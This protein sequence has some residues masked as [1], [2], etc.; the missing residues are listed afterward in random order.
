MGKRLSSNGFSAVEVL[1]ATSVIVVIGFISRLVWQ[2]AHT[3]SRTGGATVSVRPP[4]P[5]A[6]SYAG[7]LTAESARA[8]FSL[9]YP[10]SWKF[11]E[12][13]S[14]KDNVEHITLD[15]AN[16]HITIDSYSAESLASAGQPAVGCPDCAAVIGTDSV[17]LHGLGSAS[18]DAVTYHLDSGYS[19]ALVLMRPGSVYYVPSPAKAGVLTTFR[20]IS[21]LASLQAYQAEPPGQFAA[22][23]D[24]EV[25]K[26]IFS[27]ISY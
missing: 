22:S 6:N 18:I 14:S 26:K 20:G 8:G 7:W 4:A 10:A 15:D 13:V 5:P 1:L 25:A 19:N 3:T 12:S 23:P 27:S 2:H 21:N 24:L 16:F 17:T 11:S 9:K